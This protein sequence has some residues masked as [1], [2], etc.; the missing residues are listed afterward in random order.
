MRIQWGCGG[1]V[2]HAFTPM[3]D[4]ANYRSRGK[5]YPWTNRASWK[6]TLATNAAG[7]VSNRVL[8]PSG[9]KGLAS[10]FSIFCW[11]SASDS[12]TR[13]T[14][15][16]LAAVYSLIQPFGRASTPFASRAWFLTEGKCKCRQ[17]SLGWSVLCNSSSP[18][19]HPKWSQVHPKPTPSPPQVHPKRCKCH[20]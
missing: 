1:Q 3:L 13:H 2:S 14:D 11:S 17:L 5:A 15:T 18:Q 19:V 20:L 7:A 9:T 4:L 12:L 8:R 16:C 6:P 10:T